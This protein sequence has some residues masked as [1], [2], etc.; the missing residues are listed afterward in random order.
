MLV[1]LLVAKDATVPQHPNEGN[2][3][4]ACLFREGIQALCN[5]YYAYYPICT[6]GTLA[7]SEVDRV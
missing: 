2:L 6:G 5:Q 7:A 3:I 4:Q 1:S